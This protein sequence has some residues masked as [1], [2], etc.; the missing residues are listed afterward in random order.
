VRV[1]Q[2]QTPNRVALIAH[3][4]VRNGAAAIRARLEALASEGAAYAIVDALNDD[5]LVALGAAL[6]NAHLAVGGSGIALGLPAN[7]RAQGAVQA[8]PSAR[9]NIV[10]P[11]VV[12]AGSCSQATRAQVAAFVRVGRV[13]HAELSHVVHDQQYVERVADW[14]MQQPQAALVAT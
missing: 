2:A 8:P 4:V 9:A 14:C 1:L 5:D 3:E 6:A 10:A 11:A 12:L 7:F 13:L